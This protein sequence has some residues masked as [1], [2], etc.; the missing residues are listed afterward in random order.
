MKRKLA[1][2]CCLSFRAARN[3]AVYAGDA[4]SSSTSSSRRRT[5]HGL[6]VLTKGEHSV[7]RL[8]VLFVYHDRRTELRD[9]RRRSAFAGFVF[10][11]DV[12]DVPTKCKRVF[13]SVSSAS[14]HAARTRAVTAGTSD[15][16]GNA[17]KLVE[18]LLKALHP[19]R[20]SQTS[21]AFETH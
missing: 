21:S 13:H 10:L 6:R 19:S 2:S 1:F 20:A 17:V 18:D 14:F 15:T 3:R 9:H 16:A 11:V 4:P 12:C 5:H 8:T 7:P